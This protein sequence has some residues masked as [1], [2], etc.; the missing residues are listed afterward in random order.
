MLDLFLIKWA[1][2]ARKFCDWNVICDGSRCF[3][4]WAGVSWGGGAERRHDCW[5]PVLGVKTKLKSGQLYG[6]ELQHGSAAGSRNL[7][8]L[9]QNE[10]NYCVIFKSKPFPSTI[11]GKWIHA[12]VGFFVIYNAS[13]FVFSNISY[14]IQSMGGPR[15]LKVTLTSNKD[16]GFHV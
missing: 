16:H 9:R 8:V 12:A 14:K 15:C 10:R 7:V 11:R 13:R 6:K 3:S 2:S 4:V 5:Q 1:P